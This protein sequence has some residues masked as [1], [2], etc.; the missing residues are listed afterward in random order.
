M[1][2]GVEDL[3]TTTHVPLNNPCH[4]RTKHAME[5]PELPSLAYIKTHSLPP[6]PV[7]YD[8]LDGLDGHAFQQAEVTGGKQTP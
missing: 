4:K 8:L 3:K 5:G 2:K 1:Q 6:V 7:C